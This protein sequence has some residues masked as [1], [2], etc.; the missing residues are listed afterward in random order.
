M[1]DV[2]PLSAQRGQ[3][4]NLDPRLEASPDYTLGPDSDVADFAAPPRRA[5]ARRPV[6]GLGQLIA[7]TIGITAALL[8]SRTGSSA[9]TAWDFG[10]TSS[11][12]HG[13]PLSADDSRQIDRLKPQKQAEA[14]LEKAVGH[15]NGAVEQISSRVDRWQGKVQWNPQIATLTTAA[16]NSNDMRVRESGIE[17][18]L[19]AYGLG[20]N[21]ASLNYLLKTAQSTDHARKIW[22]LWALGLMANR[23]VEPEH[24]VDVLTAHL[25]DA[26]AESRKWSVEG[27]ALAGTDESAA[28][29]VKAMHD[30]AASAVR[31]RA[32]C[33][34]AEAGM[35]SMQQR[36]AAVPQLLTYTDDASLDAQ[37]HAWA[38]QALAE[39]THERLPNDSSAWRS[40]YAQASGQ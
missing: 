20:K 34:I 18:E 36:M 16:L 12:F 19:A 33:A 8:F 5:V 38:F 2:Q 37:T 31:E 22:A 35:F 11:T 7:V 30:D 1:E 10:G 23:G 28:T 26:D 40:W 25:R 13:K 29:V 17:V 14:L 15:S 3:E 27:L 32:A 21:A 6:F 9:R 4:S 24:I 39:I